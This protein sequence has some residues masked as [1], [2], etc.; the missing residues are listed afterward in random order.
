MFPELPRIRLFS[1]RAKAGR[2]AFAIK[3][4]YA[5]YYSYHRLQNNRYIRKAKSGDAHS[6]V[7]SQQ[8][9]RRGQWPARVS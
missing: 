6:G 9:Q 5:L 1:H 4:P 3:G 7:R 8:E 2:K